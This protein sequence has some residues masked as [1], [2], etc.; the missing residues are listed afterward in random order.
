[1]RVR[2]CD[3]GSMRRLAPIVLTVSALS[4]LGVA[5]CGDDNADGSAA[6]PS[7]TASAPSTPST[8]STPQPLPQPPEAYRLPPGIPKSSSGKATDTVSARVITK[9]LTALSKGDIGRAA[10]FFALP[11][12]VQNGTSVL[13]LR[14]AGDREI[15]NEAFPCGARATKLQEGGKGF[16]IVDFV[17]TERAGGDCQGATGGRARSAIRVVDGHITDWYRLDQLT[18]PGAPTPSP[19]DPSVPGGGSI[20]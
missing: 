17:L 3:S 8:P 2:G 5:G 10:R 7:P 12:R 9:W 18:T 4:V 15:F 6:A 19:V 11:A 14:K 1:M 20:A 16:T 13:T